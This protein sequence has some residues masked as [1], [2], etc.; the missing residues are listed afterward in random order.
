LGR[1]NGVDGEE[2]GKRKRKHE[3]KGLQIM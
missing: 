2:L 3:F 1:K